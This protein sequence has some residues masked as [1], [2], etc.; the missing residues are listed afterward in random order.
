MP[1]LGESVAEGTVT[2]WLVREGDFVEREVVLVTVAT[3]KADTEIRS[4]DRGRIAKLVAKE[5]EIVAKGGLLC[6]IDETAKQGLPDVKGPTAATVAQ[7]PSAPAPNG[8][9]RRRLRRWQRAHGARVAVDAQDGPRAGRRVQATG[10][11]GRTKRRRDRARPTRL[12]CGRRRRRPP[13]PRALHSPS[14]P[15]PA[16]PPLHASSRADAYDR[17][18][19]AASPSRRWVRAA[20][21]GRR[22]RQIQR[23][24]VHAATGR[25]GRSLQSPSAHHRRPHGLF[26]DRLAPRGDGGR[27]RHPSDEQ[28]PRPAQGPA[29][30]GR[31]PAHVPRVHLAPR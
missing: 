9:A 1:Q 12:A 16:L 15:A 29:Q 19:F 5:D 28:A 18:A 4:P 25:R 13:P 27:S 24:P 14:A 21:P 23:P 3:D 20:D 7:A 31:H 26:E 2:K 17:R 6:Q 8:T 10:E 11:H 30:E 22:L